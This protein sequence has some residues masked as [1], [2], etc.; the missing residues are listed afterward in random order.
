MSLFMV[1][2]NVVSSSES[3]QVT[4]LIPFTVRRDWRDDTDRNVVRLDTRRQG[5]GGHSI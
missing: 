3:R 2:Q 4:S 5:R 1:M